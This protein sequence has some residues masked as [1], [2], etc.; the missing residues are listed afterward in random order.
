VKNVS[1]I[2]EQF[3][4]T[5]CG[6]CCG[7]C[8][9]RC[10]E[11]KLNEYGIYV[12]EIE[13]AICNECELC[14]CVCPGYEFN[15][16]EYQKRIFGKLPEHIGL[17]NYREAYACYTQD[18]DILSKCQSGGFVST[19]IIHCL[20]KKLIDGAVVSKWKENSPFEPE[21][22]IARTRQQVLDAVGSKYNPVPAAQ[23]IQE[24]L[25]QKGKYIFV[26]T[27]CQIQA[28]R[29]T[30]KAFPKLKD[31]IFL[32]IGLHCLGVF[33]YHF[34]DQ[35]CYKI[36]KNKKD[37]KYFRHR[38]K[39]WRG[40]PCD[41]RMKDKEGEVF[42]IDAKK[43]RLNP[44][45]FF[46]AWRC[47]LCF[48]KANEFSD[49][50]CGDCRMPKMHKKISA[51]GYD[52]KRGLSEFVVR[53][54]RGEKIINDV[55]NQKKI[56]VWKADP[57]DIAS[58]IGLEKKLGVSVFRKIA[59]CFSKGRPEYGVLFYNSRCKQS[60]IW[61]LLTP[62][63]IIGSL[64]YYLFYKFSRFAFFRRFMKIVPHSIF[65]IVQ[66]YLKRVILWMRFKKNVDIVLKIT[67]R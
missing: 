51:E 21:T 17:G 20:E 53:T 67:E 66:K 55:I 23:I 12:P 10:I 42:D 16:I 40:W 30:E 15:Y 54:Q 41:M 6:A 25:K 4:C 50:S 19:I 39:E 33:T 18:R 60:L 57:N 46:T 52:L 14:L 9:K 2:V 44:R 47:Q 56:K 65:G 24:L 27:S 61:N 49:V 29:K 32:Y 62:W 58:S 63:T 36:R 8:P 48:D 28:M 43:S 31:K 37:I 5:S 22:Y 26:G 34:H 59:L 1:K 35:M 38:S 64:L 3:L 45:P 13:E 7:A 11:M